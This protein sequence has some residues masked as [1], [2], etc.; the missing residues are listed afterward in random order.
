MAEIRQDLKERVQ[1]TY[2]KASEKRAN[3]IVKGV[4]DFLTVLERKAMKC[5]DKDD[6]RL[7]IALAKTWLDFAVFNRSPVI[8]S[9]KSEAEAAGET[10]CDKE[11]VDRIIAKV[12][13]G[14]NN[15]PTSN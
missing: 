13:N 6:N 2:E 11:L 5:F 10:L 8:Q 15:K 14:S 7:G 1:E 9:I 4:S 12:K 3:Y